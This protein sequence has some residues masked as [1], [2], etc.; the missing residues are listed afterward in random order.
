MPSTLPLRPR[1]RDRRVLV[2]D[3][4]R[5]PFDEVWIPVASAAEMAAAIRDMAVRGAP[6]V[7]LA[8]AWGMVLAHLAGEDPAEAD[9]CLRS[10]R[11]T[12][13]NL[14]H[15]LDRMRPDWGDPKASEIR[16]RTLW[17]EVKRAERAIVRHGSR[18]L[19]GRV[20]THCNTG[21]LATGGTGT[22]LGAIVEGFRQGRITHVWVD[23]TRPWLQG[24]R[25]TAWEL[26]REGV[27]HAVITDSTSA[28]LMARGEVDAVAVGADRMAMNGDFANK[29]GTYG[30]SVLARHHDIPFWVMLPLSSL[31]ARLAT[32]E[33][34]P[35]EER[36]QEEVRT[37]AGRAIAPSDTPFRNLAFDVTPHTLVT[38]IVTE[39]GAL[40]PPFDEGLLRWTAP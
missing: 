21:P 34:I 29:I 18:C 32:G 26:A 2:L 17:R 27:P 36:P 5:L 10:A 39:R 7:G 33:G 9:A 8:A 40:L 28:A 6:A 13:V 3:Q 11:P 19:A 14:A 23:E 31:D 25:L 24:A 35:I 20:L 30:L 1:I 15:A 37:F 4:R 16:A 38:G 22:A 12:A